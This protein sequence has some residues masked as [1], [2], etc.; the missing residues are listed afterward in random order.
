MYINIT[1]RAGMFEKDICVD[2][3]Q[4]IHTMTEIMANHGRFP[5]LFKLP[6]FYR[7]QMQRRIISSWFTFEEEGIAD[8]DCLIAVEDKMVWTK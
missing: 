3:R 8:G 5:V 6:D 7:S 2:S 1:I 4:K